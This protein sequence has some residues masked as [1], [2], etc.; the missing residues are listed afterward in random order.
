MSRLPSLRTATVL[1]VALGMVGFAALAAQPPGPVRLDSDAGAQRAAQDTPLGKIEFHPVALTDQNKPT[2]RTLSH[3]RE[4]A[5]T[6]AGSKVFDVRALKSTVIRLERPEPG[7]STVESDGADPDAQPADP[8]AQPADPDAQP[9]DPDQELPTTVNP[10]SFSQGQTSNAPAPAPNTSFDGLDFTNWGAGHP[11]DDN[12]DVGPTYYI[13]TINSSLGIYQKSNGSRVAAFTFNSFMSQGNFGNLCDTNNFGDP[14]VLY[15]TYE[16]RWFITDF[17]F[18]HRWQRQRQP[19]DRLPVLCRV[20]DG[21][22]G[23][24]RLELLFD[25]GSGRSG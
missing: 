1:V 11:P 24:R 21:R 4:L 19:A 6:A 20:Q 10:G 17:A 2:P 15:D 12:G 23:Q 5:L 3:P 25:P 16:D 8:D 22:P 18:A 14:V 9:P 7:E 13:Q